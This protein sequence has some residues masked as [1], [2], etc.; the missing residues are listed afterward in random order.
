VGRDLRR[1]APPELTGR[2]LFHFDD[3]AVDAV[4]A[5]SEAVE[6]SLDEASGTYT[7]IWRY[8][9]DQRISSYLLGDVERLE[10]GNTL[11]AWGSGGTITEVTP[12]GDLAFQVSLAIGPA[13]GFTHHIDAPGGLPTRGCPCGT[14]APPPPPG[15]PPPGGSPVPHQ[16]VARR[17]NPGA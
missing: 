6:Y 7:P 14:R 17:G 1:Q 15:P 5:Y 4:N 10:N 2:A 16:T 9:Y 8:D 12:E 13:P 11:I 3:G